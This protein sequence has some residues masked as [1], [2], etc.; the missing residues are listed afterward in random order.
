MTRLHADGIG[1]GIPAAGMIIEKG[2][3]VW[4]AMLASD[5]TSRHIVMGLGGPSPEHCQTKTCHSSF[6][7]GHI[8]DFHKSSRTHIA[9]DRAL[10]IVVVGL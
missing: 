7:T 10:Y 2:V 8:C 9:I 1:C 5:A 6:T 4:T 3:C